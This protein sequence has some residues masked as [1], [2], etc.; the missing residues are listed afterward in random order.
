MERPPPRVPCPSRKASAGDEQ[1][2]EEARQGGGLTTP[3]GEGG[4]SD[5]VHRGHLAWPTWRQPSG[6]GPSPLSTGESAQRVRVGIRA[7][8]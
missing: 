2:E 4:P 7:G 3:N 1:G 5:S 8:S 6:P